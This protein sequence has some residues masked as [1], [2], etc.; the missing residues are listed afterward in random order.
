MIE[1]P[2]YRPEN[3]VQKKQRATELDVLRGF[4]VLLMIGHHLMYDIHYIF[5]YPYFSWLFGPVMESTYHPLIYILFLGV[6]GISSSFS[7]N[8]LKRASR[9]ALIALGLTL[10]TS[11]I[12]VM[13]KTD[14]YILWQVIHC[15][16]L[17]TLLSAWLEKSKISEKAKLV[18]FILLGFLILFFIPNIFEAFDLSRQGTP[19]LLPFGIGYLRPE[20][21]GMLDYLPLIPYSG[22]FFIGNALGKIIY[23][24]GVVKKQYCTGKIFKPLALMG[25]RAL[26]IYAVHQP[27]LIALI[28]IWRRI[29]G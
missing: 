3:R 11:L 10:V 17:C 29:I 7:R 26:I 14:F 16:A 18:I 15:L 13:L 9:L 6:A 21:P 28:W 25:R 23:P 24:Q 8:N 27:I 19:W 4:A 22:C 12:S 1:T 20:V 2:E 5:G